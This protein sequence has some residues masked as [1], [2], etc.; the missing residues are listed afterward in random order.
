[1]IS[2]TWLRW[3]LPNR[4]LATGTEYMALWYSVHAC[5]GARRI[6][7]KVPTNLTIVTLKEATW[8]APH[9]SG[10]GSSRREAEECTVD[11]ARGP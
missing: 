4:I 2:S 11:V 10:A 6:P 7:S 8:R 1:L 5:F 9:P 3:M